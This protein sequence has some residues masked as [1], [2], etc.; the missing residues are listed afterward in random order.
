MSLE[1]QILEIVNRQIAGAIAEPMGPPSPAI[2]KRYRDDVIASVRLN[3][4]VISAEPD[5]DDPLL[6]NVVAR[7]PRPVQR[8]TF[9]LTDGS[10]P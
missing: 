10:E 4:G 5:P 9:T 3:P 2:I 7:D 1:D 6:I 8:I